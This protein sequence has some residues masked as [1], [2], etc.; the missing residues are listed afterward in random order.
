[1]LEGLG[2]VYSG[3]DATRRLEELKSELA[4]SPPIRISHY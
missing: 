3:L 1:M 2:R 4:K